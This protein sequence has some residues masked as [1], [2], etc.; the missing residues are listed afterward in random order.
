M[1]SSWGGRRHVAV[2]ATCVTVGLTS[3]GWLLT[4]AEQTT[5]KGNSNVDATAQQKS[6]DKNN[7][8]NAVA[9]TEN[10]K[11]DAVEKPADVDVEFFDF[12]LVGGGMASYMALQE[13]RKG[14]PEARILVLGDE[15]AAKGP[16]LR[17]PL[18]KNMWTA[19]ADVAN[20]TFA[21]AGSGDA[22]AQ[23]EPASIFA[24]EQNGFAPATHRV[25]R[26]ERLEAQRR[27]VVL[28]N[29]TE[30]AYG[31]CLLA[32]GAT[33]VGLRHVADEVK[34]NVLTFRGLKDFKKLHDKVASGKSV[35]VVGGGL[36]GTE[37]ASS[38]S[39][40]TKVSLFSCS[41]LVFLLTFLFQSLLLLKFIL[42]IIRWKLTFLSIWPVF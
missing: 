31:R 38:L 7:K 8:E 2:T 20:W 6:S 4:S 17:P 37:L 11:S 13:L 12:V 15:D 40:H 30:I 22:D 14:A 25:A 32:T 39:K 27:R 33:P 9:Q 23:N 1:L 42:V 36:L 28:A 26:V 3:C 16:Y 29:G 24:D 10:A 35:T 41:F 19:G 34:D 18:S 21:S 5:Q